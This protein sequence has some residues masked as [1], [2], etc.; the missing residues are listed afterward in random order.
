MELLGVLS[1]TWPARTLGPRVTATA[2]EIGYV[3]YWL[4]V[5]AGSCFMSVTN[6]STLLYMVYTSAPSSGCTLPGSTSFGL[7]SSSLHR[8][9]V[10]FHLPRHFSEG[11]VH[12]GL[13]CTFLEA[14]NFV[15]A[16]DLACNVVIG[17][18]WKS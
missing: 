1:L 9:W 3:S 13:V 2:G 12:F 11:V 7:I 16:I 10:I 5:C 17:R 15:N 4:C 18:S 14:E 6:L 8:T